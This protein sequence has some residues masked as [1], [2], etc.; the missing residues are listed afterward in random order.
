MAGYLTDVSGIKVGHFTS[1]LRPTGCTVILVEKGAIA[2][3][4][5]RGGA[6]GTRETDLLNPINTIQMVHSIVFSGGSAFGLDTASGVMRY[7]EENEIGFDTKVAHIPIVPTAVIFDLH[8]GDSKVRPT[9]EDGYKAAKEAKTGTFALGNVGA[10]AGATVGKL[11]GAE[12][13]T[14]GGLGTASIILGDLVVAA[15]AVVN[16]VGDI[17]DPQTGSCVA[18]A[19]SN[20]GDTLLDSM[21]ALRNGRRPNI[22]AGQNTTLGLIATN[23]KLTKSEATKLA[24]MS[25]AGF[26]RTINPV[27]TPLDGDT[28]FAISTGDYSQYVDMITLGALAADVMANAVLSAIQHATAFEKIPAAADLFKL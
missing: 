9:A 21:T 3:V 27:H 23:A 15:L 6:P 19:R 26:S 25:H 1:G 28:I 18:G 5:V 2:G 7:L 14:R 11:F 24:E 17:I 16:A 22:F 12:H 13:S 20:E 10:G 8:L 4:D